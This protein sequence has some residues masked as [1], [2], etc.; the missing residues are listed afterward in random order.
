MRKQT[1][2]LKE[3]LKTKKTVDNGIHGLNEDLIERIVEL[4]QEHN[5]TLR[6][7]NSIFAGN[8]GQ[9]HICLAGEVSFDFLK[10]L[11]DEFGPEKIRVT[12]GGSTN[13]FGKTTSSYLTV[14]MDFNEG[15]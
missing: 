6:Y 10:N 7:D 13:I 8:H 9:L 4:I 12:G 3:L 15:E 14:Y 5:L 2:L 1:E 11:D